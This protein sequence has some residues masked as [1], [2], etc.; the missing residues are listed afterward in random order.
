MASIK[1]RVKGGAN[2]TAPKGSHNDVWA[3]LILCPCQRAS[4][5]RGRASVTPGPRPGP[6]PASPLTPGAPEKGG[7]QRLRTSWVLTGSQGRSRVP[8]APA[9]APSLCPSCP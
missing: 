3:L 8:A 2:M 5:A 7:S 4:R 9:P 6:G 1:L